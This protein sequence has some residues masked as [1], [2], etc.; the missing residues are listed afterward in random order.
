MLETRLFEDA[1]Q[2]FLTGAMIDIFDR[3]LTEV[4]RE[5]GM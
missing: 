2:L 1:V 5:L 4:E 3:S